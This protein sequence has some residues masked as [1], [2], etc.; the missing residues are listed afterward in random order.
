MAYAAV[1]SLKGTLHL[2]F[3]Q[4]Q[5]RLPLMYKPKMVSLHRNLSF[6][7][8][9]REKSEMDYDDA[10]VMKDV[11]A[12]IRD[13]AFEAEERIEME[14]T[15]IY[16]EAK[17]WAKRVACL[18]RLHEIFIQ[19]V[20][21]TDYL[22]KKLINIQSE[23]QLA[24]GPSQSERM[25]QRGLL[26]GST[27]SQPDLEH[28]NNITVNK[29][30][31][32]A[33][34]KFD[35]TMVGCNEE[36]K[37][38]MDQLTRQSAKKLQVVSIVG[39]GGIGKTTLARKVYEDSS[40]TLHFD[41]RAWVTVSHEY[42][43]LQMLQCLVG[44]VSASSDKQSSNDTSELA[45]SLRKHLMG[46]RYLIVMDD[47]WSKEA[48]D[49]VQRC[50]PDDNKG[51][52]ILLTSRYKE[53]VE[54]AG[55][56]TI[57]MSFLDV[58]ES[59]NLFCNVFGQTKFVSVFEQ[60]SRKI[61]EKCNGLPLAI[62]VIASLLSKTE[63]AVE[64]WNNVAENVSRY[65]I[66]DSNDACSRILYLSYNQLP[67]HLKACFLYFG[68][69]PEDCE[70]HVKKLVR[71]WAA[72]GF[73][74]AEDHR[75][76]E[77]VAMKCLQDL[78]DRSLVFVSKQSYNGKMKTIRIHDLLRDLCLREARYENLVNEVDDKNHPVYKKKI[79]CRWMGR[80]SV[81]TL[82]PSAECFYRS[83]SIHH[84][85]VDYLG[86]VE[87]LYSSFKLLRVVD[88]E[89]M[90]SC[91]HGVIYALANLIHLRY[92]SL[93]SIMY[94][95]C[96]TYFHLELFEHW[97]MQSFIVH[98]ALDSFDA[99]GIW[100][101]PLLRNFCIQ[102]I[103][104]LGSLSVVHRNLESIS[105]LNS[106]L[107]TKDLFTMIPN[108]KKLGVCD[109][110]DEKNQDCFYS[111]EHLEQLEELSI[112]GWYFNHIPCSDISW[113]TSF[114]P[115]LKKLKFFLTSLAWNDMRLIG[116]LPNLEV[117]KLKHAIVK[118]D[119]IWET[120]EEGF[121]KLKRLVIEYEW[122]E[123]WSAE[124]DHF[125]LLECL[126]ICECKYLR[127]IPSGFANIT[128]LALI[129]LNRCSDSVLDSAKSIQEE[130]NSNYGNAFHVRSE[131]GVDKYRFVSSLKL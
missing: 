42:N 54:Y 16:L 72:E 34:I 100:K 26:H 128:T 77:E 56:S 111:F 3:L 28:E 66:S 53:V 105:W 58:N 120:S 106:K 29:L 32:N 24:K 55:N 119:K 122:L 64:K 74:R 50:F 118:E 47:I 18:L 61:V 38:I 101:M 23:K 14:L 19:A 43:L 113:A 62:I 89:S 8:E 87:S 20:K 4:S 52:H 108:L 126:E 1:T 12:E 107:C 57:N 86:S 37:T 95:H 91:E 79:S 30:S 117:L 41:K 48:W 71:L 103:D 40:I 68:V 49:S 70:I 93:R 22:K 13:A 97:N 129:Q 116:L 5:P 35:S 99:Y 7:Q 36:F 45:A 88:I 73:L 130:Q 75:N 92:L 2:H 33:S 85:H 17:G 21:Q 60:I 44:C 83:H 102:R 123:H 27:S 81:F 11:E 6:L 109:R 125:P 51:S 78:V 46:Q 31:K 104:S 9:S 96:P 25:R 39:M 127:E 110:Y 115:N 82:H 114:L 131:M 112:R 15:N 84:P 94:S 76:M 10:G 69:F 80:T 124:S 59:W 98:G 63:A 67:H 121:R 65:V 90:P